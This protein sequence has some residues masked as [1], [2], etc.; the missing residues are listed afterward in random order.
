[1][2]F[3]NQ[4]GFN[5]SKSTPTTSTT[6]TNTVSTLPSG[7][8]G[9]LNDSFTEAA[10]SA[11]KSPFL[12]NIL[13][14]GSSSNAASPKL[15]PGSLGISGAAPTVVTISSD[16]NTNQTATSLNQA[17][18]SGGS[19][20]KADL[21]GL[22][23]KFDLST[24]NQDNSNPIDLDDGEEQLNEEKEDANEVQKKSDIEEELE[25]IVKNEKDS[26]N[27]SQEIHEVKESESNQEHEQPE[28]E[29]TTIIEKNVTPLIFL[30]NI[31]SKKIEEDINASGDITSSQQTSEDNLIDLGPD[32]VSTVQQEKEQSP[33]HISDSSKPSVETIDKVESQISPDL[34]PQEKEKEQAIL[35]SSPIKD[36]DSTYDEKSKGK[37]L[38]DITGDA[39]DQSSEIEEFV[40]PEESTQ[41]HPPLKR[42]DSSKIR[43][44]HESHLAKLNQPQVDPEEQYQQSHRPFDFQHF[45]AQLR[46]KGADPLVRYIRSFLVSFSRSGHTFTAEQRI[47]IIIEFKS[48]MNEKFGLYEPFASMDEID[49]ENSREGLEKLIMNRLHVHCFPPEVAQQNNFLPEPF[50]KDLEDDKA[51]SIQLEKFS[52]INGG[53]LDID[54]EQLTTLKKGEMNF[55]DYA[56]AELNKINNYRAPRDK[57][58]CILNAC[59]IIFSFLKVSNQ[60]TNADAFI[61]LLILII[62]KAKTDNLISNIHY[63]EGY[64]S[65]EWLLHGETSYY[66]SSLQGAIGFIQNLSDKELTITEEEYGAHMEAWAAQEKNRLEIERASQSIVQPQP[67][68]GSRLA[69]QDSAPVQQSLSPSSVLLSSAEIFTKSISNFLS[70]SPQD[71]VSQGVP[72]L[73]PRGEY[74]S[75]ESQYPHPQ[76]YPQ[77]YPQQHQPP[78]HQQYQQPEEPYNS[79]SQYQPIPKLNADTAVEQP[80]YDSEE[81]KKVYEN[82]KE[83]FPT[84]DDSILK[85]LVYMNKGDIDACIDACLQLVNDV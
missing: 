33:E 58:I 31:K 34:K 37:D 72:Q 44:Q 73:P 56:I 2:A 70:P 77:Q 51:F 18:I 57:I 83:I 71:P 17:G 25:S 52:W 66:L 62:I 32:P 46:R 79:Y 5:I 63:I 60:E 67:Q 47:K 35:S 43:L 53:H 3:S 9:T 78:P 13:S 20:G 27:S 24:T 4:L 28:D 16:A 49:L 82:V 59:K 38:S 69:V 10:G 12:S 75:G 84:M 15:G 74:Q 14:K 65:E 40:L 39:E 50:A 36:D 41:R 8:G 1:M 26:N 30:S 48:F 81:L 7:S 21:I 6:N 11:S 61:P 80:A 55:V 42:A 64:R 22:F 76:R 54:M 23:D 45:L 19:G 29:G 68:H 85:D